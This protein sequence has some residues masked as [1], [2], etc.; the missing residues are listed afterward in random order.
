MKENFIKQDSNANSQ[1]DHYP[2]FFTTIN[3][4]HLFIFWLMKYHIAIMGQIGVKK[5]FI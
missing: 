2:S 3:A 1:A 5:L 4:F